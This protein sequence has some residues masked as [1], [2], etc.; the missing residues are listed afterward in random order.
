MSLSSHADTPDDSRSAVPAVPPPWPGPRPAQPVAPLM[1]R[2]VR[3]ADSRA[4]ASFVLCVGALVYVGNILADNFGRD[5]LLPLA[6]LAM[7]PLAICLAGLWWVDRWDPEPKSAVALALI[8]GAGASV[9][10]TLLLGRFVFAPIV[11]ATDI[12]EPGLFGAVVQAPVVEELAKGLGVLLIFLVRGS[13]FDG[14]VDGIVYGGAVGAGF[15]FTE[16]ILYFASATAAGGDAV[17]EMFVMRGLFSPFAHVLFTAWTGFALGLAASRGHRRWWVRYFIVGLVPAILGHFLWNGGLAVFFPDFWSFYVL[18]QVPL[19]IC[20]VV[21]VWLLRRA[22]RR[23]TERRLGDY[24]K[25]GWFTDR[26]VAMLSTA[27]G[28]RAAASW[29]RGYGAG[30]LMR[31][32]TTTAVRLAAERHRIVRGHGVEA[33]QRQEQLLLQRALRQ[34]QQLLA[35]VG[36][37]R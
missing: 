6:F 1:D 35:Q 33:A 15:A 2:L 13:H 14:P 22:E 23:L 25:A 27:A 4:S 3:F 26:E 34:R 29:A 17:A 16:N 8:W 9:G 5:V 31:D 37:P 20:A 21:A 12:A 18:L 19:F 30:G 24:R 11:A 28:R 32:F 36:A 7:V 10:G